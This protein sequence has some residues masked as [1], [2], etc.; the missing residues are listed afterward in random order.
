MSLYS[1]SIDVLHSTDIAQHCLG[2]LAF[3]TFHEACGG[4]W[5][6]EGADGEDECRHGAQAQGHAPVVLPGPLPCTPVDQLG[7]Q[8]A[9]G[10]AARGG[11]GQVWGC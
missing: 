5:D 7:C 9:E 3:A 8:D 2:L 6:E 10:G 11:G 4:V 1:A